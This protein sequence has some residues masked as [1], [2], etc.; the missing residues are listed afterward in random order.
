MKP[1]K[2]IIT[3]SLDGD[4]KTNDA[5]RGKA[6]GWKRQLET[7]KQLRTLSGVETVLGMTLSKHNAGLYKQTFEAAK[8]VVPDLN[9][10]DFH[11]NIAHESSHYYHNAGELNEGGNQ[12]LIR[13]EVSEYQRSRGPVRSLVGFLEHQYLGKVQQYMSTGKT[14]V[15]CHSLKSSCFIDSWGNVYPCII[16]DNKI[17]N[18]RDYNYD[19]EKIWNLPETKRLQQEI[20]QGHCPN[21]WT[22]CEAYQSIL[23][24]LSRIA[25]LR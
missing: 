25:L 5:I 19:L 14:P 24:N 11:V 6:G 1:P 16:Y 22:P 20:W 8:K 13:K 7:F 3:V 23:G 17:A 21:C 10:R 2:F 4:E 12:E 15:R 9:H 18:L